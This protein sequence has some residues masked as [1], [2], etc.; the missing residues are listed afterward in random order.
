MLLAEDGSADYSP[1]RAMKVKHQLE[2]PALPIIYHAGSSALAHTQASCADVHT[3][4]SE[5]LTKQH[6]WRKDRVCPISKPAS[7]S[8]L[9]GNPNGKADFYT[10]DVRAI[11]RKSSYTASD[12]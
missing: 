12:L 1:K 6:A 9:K 11:G 8:A 4:N 7:G 10:L 3:C 5:S 2:E